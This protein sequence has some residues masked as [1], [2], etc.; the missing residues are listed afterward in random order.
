MAMA[1]A[2]KAFGDDNLFLQVRNAAN[3]LQ[4]R[5]ES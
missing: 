2:A 3:N 1:I 4:A 5:M